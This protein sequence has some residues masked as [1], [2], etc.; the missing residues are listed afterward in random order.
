LESGKETK[1]EARFGDIE[2]I[3][4]PSGQFAQL[5]LQPLHR[6][7]VG[8]GGPGRSGGVRVVG[9]ALGIVID[10]RGRPLKLPNDPEN[11]RV[12]LKRWLW[13]LGN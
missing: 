6:F 3:P 5:H 7:D 1:L 12:A 4:L 9:G 11:R 2:V 13:A 8:M 10:G